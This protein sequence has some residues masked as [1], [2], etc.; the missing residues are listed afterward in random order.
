MMNGIDP[1]TLIGIGA[2]ICL[3]ILAIYTYVYCARIR[4][5]RQEALDKM[6]QTE[7]EEYELPEPVACNA[8]VLEKH[9]AS[10]VIGTKSVKQVSSYY[11]TFFTEDGE[12][13]EY[14]VPEE[15]FLT[16]EKGQESTLITVD[17]KF[18]DF[19]DGESVE[20]EEDT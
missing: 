7:E 11:V 6:E 9:F 5:E 15:I 2:I 19:S 3:A 10:D 18:F 17:G 14:P 8:R 13:V 1:Y 4:T 16:I 12:T 20:E